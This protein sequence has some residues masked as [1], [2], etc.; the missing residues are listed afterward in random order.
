[1]TS[2]KH[3]LIIMLIGLFALTA[4]AQEKKVVIH[5]K[6]H[7]EDIH[8]EV[9]IT[10]D[11]EV[12]DSAA[13][14]IFVRKMPR[15]GR[16]AARIVI[17]KS[18]F[19]K[20]NKIIIDFDPITKKIMKVLDNGK[21]MHEKKFHK[22]Q[23]YLEDATELAPLAALHPAME[24]MD[25]KIELGELPPLEGLEGLDSLIVHLE[26]LESAHAVLKK[27]H[28][29][30][31]K[32]VI[33]LDNLAETIQNI[34]GESGAT[35]PQKIETIAIKKGKFFVNGDEIKGVTGQKCIQAYTA[36]SDLSPEEM[37]KKGEEISIQI[38]FD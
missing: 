37:E 22:Y 30:S 2:K 24:E 25:L 4:I 15:H 11:G 32:H 5:R 28:Y 20:K 23:E 33:E 9:I 31:I 34:L 14:K 13:T 8:K 1:M 19:F 7:G 36:N 12:S 29:K 10:Q 3:I 27:E 6:P 26:A 18:G 17:K 16:K 35:P 21:E 38:H